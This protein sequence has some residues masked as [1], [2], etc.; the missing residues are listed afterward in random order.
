MWTMFDNLVN[1]EKYCLFSLSC[2]C[3]DMVV[4]LEHHLTNRLH[5]GSFMKFAICTILIAY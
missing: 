4:P 3:A 2:L 5:W 1:T